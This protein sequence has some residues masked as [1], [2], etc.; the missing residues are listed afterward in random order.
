MS[1]ARKEYADIIDREHHVSKKRQQMA[2][3]NR[4]AQFAPFAALTGY[5]D[6]IRESERETDEQLDLDEDSKAA[7]NEKLVWLFH[8]DNPPEA[9]FTVLVP[10]SKKI[11]GE[12]VPVTG[13]I[14]KYDEFSQSI[15]LESGRVLFIEDISKIESD[16][17][18]E[19]IW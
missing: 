17:F 16:T 19:L 3:L 8:Q 15:T 1:D 4:A 12:Y 5:D 11:G 2:R 6:L 7:L 9:T 13:K 18:D 10:D 14:A